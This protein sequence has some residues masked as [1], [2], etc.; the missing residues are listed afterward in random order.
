M[1]TSV[2]APRFLTAFLNQLKYMVLKQLRIRKSPFQSGNFLIEKSVF[3][4]LKAAFGISG[5]YR[6]N[7]LFMNFSKVINIRFLNETDYCCFEKGRFEMRF[8]SKETTFTMLNIFRVVNDISK[9]IKISK[10][11]KCFD[12][13]KYRKYQMINISKYRN[14]KFEKYR[15]L[16]LFFFVFLL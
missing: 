15:Y 9:N 10:I 13:S 16:C 7:V 14:I 1:N 4:Y 8:V 12:I 3:N 2:V 5:A 11:S 6:P